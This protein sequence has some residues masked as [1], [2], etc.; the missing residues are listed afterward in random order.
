MPIQK[1]RSLD[2]MRR[3]LWRHPSDGALLDRIRALWARSRHISPRIYPRGVFKY[4]TIEE[5]QAARKQIGKNKTGTN[6]S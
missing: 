1:F 2:E 3:A 4:R 6:L 5:A